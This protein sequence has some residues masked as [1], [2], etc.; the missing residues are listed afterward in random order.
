MHSRHAPGQLAIE[1]AAIETHPAIETMGDGP[2]IGEPEP[3]EPAAG[4]ETRA[5]HV[6]DP[7]WPEAEEDLVAA[8]RR[9]DEAAFTRLVEAEG[10]RLLALAR[11]LLRDEE[12]A[13][14]VVQDAF[15]AAVRQ[16][17]GFRGESRLASWLHRIVI[18]LAATRLRRRGIRGETGLDDLL[19]SFESDGHV[20]EGRGT[21][22]PASPPT[23]VEGAELRAR[24][25]AAIDLLP[26][27]HR[28][29]LLLRDIEGL[30]TAETA[31]ALGLAPGAVRTRLH[32]ARQAL[33]E[34]LV[35][36]GLEP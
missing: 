32:R 36:G 16:L 14:D 6:A 2:T 22:A 34:L 19:P 9:G 30:E 12:E 28:S 11:R 5:R 23:E 4:I 21:T 35:R 31:E 26:E 7:S 24:V 13:R 3:A 29:V 18:H 8:L 25:R 17:P 10:G 27:T 33:R 1:N 20:Q 15:L